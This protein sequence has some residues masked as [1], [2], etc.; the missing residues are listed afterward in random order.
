MKFVRH[1]LAGKLLP[2]E[3]RQ[4]KTGPGLDQPLENDAEL[5]VMSVCLSLALGQTS[6][7]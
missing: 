3:L 6:R 1:R 2:A 4:L 7:S 5:L